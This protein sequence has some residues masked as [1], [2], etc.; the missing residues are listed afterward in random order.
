M[1][2]NEFWDQVKKFYFESFKIEGDKVDLMASLDILILSASGLSNENISNVVDV[3]V[4]E[5]L[6]ILTSYLNFA[7]WKTNLECNPLFI[8][9]KNPGDR[10]K[11]TSLILEDI[12]KSDS[13]I[14]KGKGITT[15]FNICKKLARLLDTLDKNWR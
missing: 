12:S 5:V 11:F 3:N 14:L 1:E 7:G 4:D 15:A 10:N 13:D 6:E 8:Y 2:N 9:G